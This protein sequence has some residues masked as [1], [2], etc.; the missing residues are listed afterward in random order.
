VGKFLAGYRN[1]CHQDALRE[2]DL[3]CIKSAYATLG[4]R[5]RDIRNP[6]GAS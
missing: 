3:G 5:V 6:V 1:P 2:G 4:V